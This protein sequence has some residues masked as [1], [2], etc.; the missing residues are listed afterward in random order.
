[1]FWGLILTF[2]EVTGETLVGGPFCTPRYP[3]PPPPSPPSWIGL[4]V[5]TSLN[6]CLKWIRPLTFPSILKPATYLGKDSTTDVCVLKPKANCF[7]IKGIHHRCLHSKAGSLTLNGVSKILWTGT[8]TKTFFC[9]ATHLHHCNKFFFHISSSFK[10]SFVY[11][12]MRT[13][14]SCFSYQIN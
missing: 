2:V 14:I 8:I 3:S 12:V 9:Y 11:K 10:Q 7:S 1:M 13:V 6:I 4:M 5:L